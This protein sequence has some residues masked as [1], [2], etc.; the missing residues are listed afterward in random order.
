MQEAARLQNRFQER[1]VALLNG[2][3]TSRAARALAILAPE[4]ALRRAIPGL[5]AGYE[6]LRATLAQQTEVGPWEI[7]PVPPYEDHHPQV[8]SIMEGLAP[9]ARWLS[10]AYVHGSLADGEQCA[11]SDFDGLVILRHEAFATP[12]RLLSMLQRLHQLQQTMTV[13]DP[14]QH[15]GWFVLTEAD[16]AWHCEAYF[17]PVLFRHAR[18]LLPGEAGNVR[19]RCRDSRAE[20]SAAFSS[21]AEAVHRKT[22]RLAP[23]ADAFALKSL[24]S[25]FMLLPALYLQCRDGQGVYKKL[26]YNLA[27]TDFGEDLWQPMERVSAI[28]RE[29]HYTLEPW[30]HHLLTRWPAG[31]RITTRWCAPA[32]PPALG[33]KLTPSLWAGM[34]RLTE[35]MQ[36][37]IP[38]TPARKGAG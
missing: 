26:S 11:Y 27:R 8:R 30:R 5:M 23:P 35:A 14:L 33:A 10:G 38:P 4:R 36:A 25:Q 17:P 16:L 9:I 15:H 13:L 7:I 1:L 18:S 6:Q 31:R 2:R 37:R 34:A 24:L 29:W 3:A 19:L 21:L 22:T 28:R 20:A 32:I 12:D